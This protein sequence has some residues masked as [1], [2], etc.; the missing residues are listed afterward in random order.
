MGKNK[1]SKLADYDYDLFAVEKRP[2]CKSW[3]A[4]RAFILK[5]V[6]HLY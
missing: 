3:K 5:R 6:S 2:N 4:I 1:T